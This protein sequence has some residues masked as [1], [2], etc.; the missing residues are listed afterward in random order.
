MA[1]EL[2][3]RAQDTH[4]RLWDV[5]ILGASP[6]SSQQSPVD[7][8]YNGF[9]IRSWKAEISLECGTSDKIPGPGRA[10]PRCQGASCSLG[11]RLFQT[12][13]LRGDH[14]GPIVLAARTNPVGLRTGLSYCW[15][16]VTTENRSGNFTQSLL[17]SWRVVSVRDCRCHTEWAPFQGLALSCFSG[18]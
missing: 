13:F 4:W 18:R 3:T 9:C 7:I 10:R 15:C 5:A 16:Q 1:H 2:H 11:L 14:C 6:W 12:L 17:C 8:P